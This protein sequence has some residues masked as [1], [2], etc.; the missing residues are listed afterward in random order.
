MCP[1]DHVKSGF[2]PAFFAAAEDDN[3]I[4]PEHTKQLYEQYS[5]DKNIVI[6]E[7]NFSIYSFLLFINHDEN[8]CPKF[9]INEDLLFS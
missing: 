3:F 7:G 1:I 8:F 5:G 6:V 2:I 4:K 9:L